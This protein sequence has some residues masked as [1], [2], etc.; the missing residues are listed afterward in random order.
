MGIET[1]YLRSRPFADLRNNALPSIQVVGRPHAL[2][3]QPDRTDQ[4]V[5]EDAYGAATIRQA[6]GFGRCGAKNVAH[7]N[8]P[9]SQATRASPLIAPTRSPERYHA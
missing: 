5:A 3:Q 6:I 4:L 1:C 2:R 7:A 9:L 8:G